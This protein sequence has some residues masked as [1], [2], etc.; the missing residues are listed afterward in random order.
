MKSLTIGTR[1]RAGFLSLFAVTLIQGIATLFAIHAMNPMTVRELV[2]QL[3]ARRAPV[4]QLT[5]WPC[6][7][8]TDAAFPMER[9]PDRGLP[10]LLRMKFDEENF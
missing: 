8:A 6:T 4:L 9:V 7:A 10:R 3:D 5:H 1:F 2:N